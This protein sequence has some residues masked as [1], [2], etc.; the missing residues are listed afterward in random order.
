[1]KMGK[2][3]TVPKLDY[4]TAGELRKYLDVVPDNAKLY[5]GHQDGDYGQMGYYHGEFTWT[6][7]I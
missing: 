1:M 2:S 6:E 3:I 5:I 7:E 4:I